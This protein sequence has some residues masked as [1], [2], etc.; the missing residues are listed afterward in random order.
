LE[1]ASALLLFLAATTSAANSLTLYPNG[2]T[3]STT[4]LRSVVGS[5]FV[6]VST[7]GTNRLYSGYLK[8][9]R[10]S[11]VKDGETSI[12]IKK[13]KAEEIELTSLPNPAISSQK[14]SGSSVSSQPEQ[15]IEDALRDG[16]IV[17]LFSPTSSTSKIASSINSSVIITIYDALGNRVLSSQGMALPRANQFGYFWNGRNSRDAPWEVEPTKLLLRGIMELKKV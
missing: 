11:P 6:G 15:L 16:G 8:A 2:G 7:S 13:S 12:L 10:F 14:A 17:L 4:Q 3:S 9:D 1:R 5:P